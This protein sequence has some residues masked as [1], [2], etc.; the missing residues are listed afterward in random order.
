MHFQNRLESLKISKQATR[1]ECLSGIELSSCENS[2][3]TSRG[4]R[5]VLR[6]SLVAGTEGRKRVEHK[7]TRIVDVRCVARALTCLEIHPFFSCFLSLR[8][9]L[10]RRGWPRGWKGTSRPREWIR[11]TGA[12]RTSTRFRREWNLRGCIC[13]YAYAYRRTPRTLP[14]RE[15]GKGRGRSFQ[16]FLLPSRPA[17]SRDSCGRIRAIHGRSLALARYSAPSC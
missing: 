12:A 17:G 16:F 13:V 1:R 11:H 3:G 10:A 5:S 2:A 6:P 4:I 7:C 8:R 9:R 15:K 14:L